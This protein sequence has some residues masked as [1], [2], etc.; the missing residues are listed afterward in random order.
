M[1]QVLKQYEN[2]VVDPKTQER[3]NKP[4]TDRTGLNDGHEEFLKTLMSQLNSGKI[5]PLNI[6]TLYNKDVYDKLSEEDQEKADVTGL[7]IM[8]IVK[9]IDSLT[10]LEERPT[11]QIQNLVETVF[12]MKSKFE[13]EH[14]DV[15]II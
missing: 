3:L 10:K 8:S 6:K 14:G 9:Q 2:H 1:D 12:Q 15:Y 5:D 11:F 13:K 4:L 7:N